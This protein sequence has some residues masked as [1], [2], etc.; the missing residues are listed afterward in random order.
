M[1]FNKIKGYTVKMLGVLCVVALL[2][3]AIYVPLSFS[4]SAAAIP[5][6][7]DETVLFT[8]SDEEGSVKNTSDPNNLTR[9]DDGIGCVGWG[10]G[11]YTGTTFPQR[12]NTL[13]VKHTNAVNWADSGGYRLNNNDGVY[14][15]EASSVYVV[16]FD[17]KITD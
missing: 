8:F 14:Y 5:V 12:Y 3:S 17:F 6:A 16:T 2:I 1:F 9:G 10:P 13:S 15:L 11:I 4:A 7:D